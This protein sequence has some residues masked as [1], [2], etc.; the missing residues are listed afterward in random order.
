[1]SSLEEMMFPEFYSL[2]G[3]RPEKK[4]YT[5]IRCRK[6]KVVNGRICNKCKNFIDAQSRMAQGDGYNLNLG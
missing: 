2:V 3:K 1:M 6:A 5:C 4:T